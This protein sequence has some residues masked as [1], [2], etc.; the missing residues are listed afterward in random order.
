MHYILFSADIYLTEA[1][2]AIK[3][4][5]HF[6]DH[7]LQAQMS[8]RCPKLLHHQLQFHKVNVTILPRVIP[9]KGRG[10]WET[11]E[12]SERHSFVGSKAFSLRSAQCS[13][14]HN[15]VPASQCCLKTFWCL[16]HIPNSALR[17]LLEVSLAPFRHKFL[18]SSVYPLYGAAWRWSLR[19]ATWQGQTWNK[20]LPELSSLSW[21][22]ILQRNVGLGYLANYLAQ[23]FIPLPF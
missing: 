18:P 20:L 5:I 21:Q 16:V 3:V 7:V 19:T 6:L 2:F 23:K 12:M 17:M 13:F 1:E 10:K 11:W 4:F 9:K 22:S 14:V 15:V 8:L